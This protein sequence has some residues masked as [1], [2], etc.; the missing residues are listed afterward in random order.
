MSQP[1]PVR[2][3]EVPEE[4]LVPFCRDLECGDPVRMI[5]AAGA[6]L[7]AEREDLCAPHFE[8]LTQAHSGLAFAPL[9]E[10]LERNVDE[11]AR[12]LDEQPGTTSRLL[13]EQPGTSSPVSANAAPGE[14]A[15][16][17]WKN[18]ALRVLDCRQ[19]IAELE[20]GSAL[21]APDAD[22]LPPQ[23]ARRLAELD[24][25]LRPLLFHLVPLRDERERA[26]ERVHQRNR[27]SLFWYSQGLDVPADAPSH[28]EEVAQLVA[29]FPAARKDLLVRM[30]THAEWAA[31]MGTSNETE[32]EA[33][34]EE[35]A[36]MHSSNS[37][38]AHVP[39]M[40]EDGDVSLDGHGRTKNIMWRWAA[41]T[42]SA[43]AI[44]MTFFGLSFYTAQEAAEREKAALQEEAQRLRTEAEERV[45]KLEQKLND[46]E[47]LSAAQR[48]A[49]EE[50]LA[51]AKREA[52]A[53][54]DNAR[55]KNDDEQ[56]NVHA[57]PSA[58]PVRSKPAGSKPNCPPGDP[59]CGGL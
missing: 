7:L 43:A 15:E 38:P 1:E 23:T 46:T 21:V 52:N 4:S 48:Q 54:R 40:A 2:W 5:A 24:A 51:E 12:L 11:L 35:S 56:S 27:E 10:K 6:L 45:R 22:P 19:Q 32:A 47:R 26:L 33:E 49:L 13:D 3:D 28:L 37:V 8:A 9:I 34:A 25:R 44:A 53:H 18:L 50:Q 58:K 55:G 16:P 20:E 14:K 36:S 59:M 57:A 39:P 17:L 31:M 42:A 30:E 41:V 29:A